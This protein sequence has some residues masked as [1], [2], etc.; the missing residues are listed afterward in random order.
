MLVRR[1]ASSL[2]WSWGK[3]MLGLSWAGIAALGFYWGRCGSL[4]QATAAAPTPQTAPAATVP[5][6]TIVPPATSDYER[7]PVAYIYDVIPITRA[8]LGEYLIARQGADRLDLLI[9]RRI[10]EHACQEK[11]IEVTA[12]EID[13]KLAE[14]LKGLQ[15]NKLD[16]VKRMLKQYNKTLYEYKEDVIRPQLLLSKLARDRVNITEE[17]LRNAF[18]AYYGE[19]VECKV[20]VWPETE[21]EK[22]M[23]T[24]YAQICN[25]PAEFDRVAR[26]QC[27]QRLAA[28]GGLIE[29]PIGHHTLGNNPSSLELEKE[30]FSL[31]PGEMTSVKDIPE[32]CAVFK[33][34]KHF[35]PDATKRLADVQKELEAEILEKRMQLVIPE[36]F[37][38]LRAAA[39]PQR[40]LHG[41]KTQ[42]DVEREVAEELGLNKDKPATP[43]SGN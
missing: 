23:S 9:N 8:E 11:G 36:V 33:C 14:D 29:K 31:Q 39:N 20:I 30:L 35:P 41:F 42:A 26:T 40:L 7:Q 10:I 2:R 6:A 18:E 15:I 27:I 24:I 4:S 19:R 3:L 34:T 12:A 43:P 22:V 37:K 32:G 21:H 25:N 16:F 5:P 28:R 13:A 1:K 17:D 38:E